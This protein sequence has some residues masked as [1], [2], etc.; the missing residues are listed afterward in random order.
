MSSVGPE[1]LYPTN[2]DVAIKTSN[3]W[4]DAKRVDDDLGGRKSHLWRIHDGL[5]DLT[6]FITDHP[7]GSDVLEKTVGIDITEAF[8]AS[9]PIN[10]R[11][12]QAT[13]SKYFIRKLENRPRNVLKSNQ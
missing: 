9:H 7:G 13:L 8:E 10:P 4:L 5:Y 11:K 6:D 3:I 2:R 1:N 12:V